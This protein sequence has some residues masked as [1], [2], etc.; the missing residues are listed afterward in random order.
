MAGKTAGLAEVLGYGG[1][2][3]QHLWFLW[4]LWWLTI[5]L[6]I[7]SVSARGCRRSGCPAGWSSRPRPLPLADPL[8]M[9]AQAF[10][11]EGGARRSSGP[12]LRRYPADPARPGLLRDLLR[13]RCLDYG[14]N[15]RIPERWWLPTT[16]G[17]LVVFPIGMALV[18]GW[19]ASL[20]GVLGSIDPTTRRVLSIG[21]QAAYPWLMTFGLMGLFRRICPAE[22][23]AIRYVSDSAYWLYLAHLPLVVAQSSTSCGTGPCRS[24]LEIRVDRRDGH[25]VLLWTYRT[26][27]RYTWLGRFLNGPRR[28]PGAELGA[29][30]KT[31]ASW[32]R[33]TRP[34]TSGPE[35]KAV[36]LRLG[37]A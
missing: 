9:I 32:S 6:A 7:V 35:G 13:L 25:P 28:R 12:T 36:R 10:M 17:L 31:P 29:G 14:Y 3:F 18:T 22:N 20:A 1:R 5:G 34:L 11:G 15:A 23:P 4:L 30:P 33:R 37:G 24:L 21:L 26:M 8:T 16:I 19:P 2:S 27:V